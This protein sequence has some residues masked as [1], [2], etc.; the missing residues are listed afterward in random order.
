MHAKLRRVFRRPPEKLSPADVAQCDSRVLSVSRPIGAIITSPPYMNALDYVR[1]NRLRL[2]FLDRA[3]SS[4]K[5]MPKRERHSYFRGLLKDTMA[6]LGPAVV[7]GGHIVLVVGEDNRGG[8]LLDTADAVR[9]TFSGEPALHSF[10]LQRTICDLIPDIR[11][12]R[13]DLRGTKKETVLVY[14]NLA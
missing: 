7:P 8:R 2:W 5:D 9:A 1:D 3:E 10:V 4:A 11:R 12:S 6:G 13:R 14:Q